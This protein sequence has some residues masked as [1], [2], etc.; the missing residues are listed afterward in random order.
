[1]SSSNN[2]F[3]ERTSPKT[4]WS[5]VVGVFIIFGFLG[6]VSNPQDPVFSFFVIGSI[7]G[8][9][10]WMMATE[11]GVKVAKAMG[12][13]ISQQGQQQQQVGGSSSSGGTVI[14]SECGWK[15]PK[16]NNYCHDCGAELTPD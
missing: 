5:I 2:R 16:S 13:D 6:A 1:M 8:G 10:A 4:Q 7:A 11:S 9:V 3:Y 12:N 15:N 14:C